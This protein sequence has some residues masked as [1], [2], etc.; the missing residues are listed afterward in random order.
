[1]SSELLDRISPLI[2]TILR[3]PNIVPSEVSAK[4]VRKTLINEYGI[5][6]EDIQNNKKAINDR[7]LSI[8]TE[9]FPNVGNGAGESTPAA[10][11]DIQQTPMK[12]KY[13]GNLD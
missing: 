6:Q 9:V 4:N 1:M 10:R 11:E 3:S 13:Q 5:S 2:Y 8:F 7:I 12:R